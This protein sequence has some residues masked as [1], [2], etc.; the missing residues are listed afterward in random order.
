MAKETENPCVGFCD[1]ASSLVD[2]FSVSGMIFP[3]MT[4]LQSHHE[5]SF[6]LHAVSCQL[7]QISRFE[8]WLADNPEAVSG[9]G[10]GV[11]VN[12]GDLGLLE[13]WNDSKKKITMPEEGGVMD[14][15]K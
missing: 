3:L 6:A 7:C 11:D 12:G 5:F 13:Q 9:I 8:A 14:Q 10:G 2:D 4:I 15:L 1:V